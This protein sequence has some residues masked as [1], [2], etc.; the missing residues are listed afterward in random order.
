[1]FIKFVGTIEETEKAVKSLEK[2]SRHF[3]NI[4]G[5]KRLDSLFDK[6][7]FAV[8]EIRIAIPGFMFDYIRE[9]FTHELV[10]FSGKEIVIASETI[11]ENEKS[12]VIVFTE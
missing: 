9:C 1:M 5:V 10:K 6:F 8:S 3:F 4:Y 11:E 2:I 7:G 12:V